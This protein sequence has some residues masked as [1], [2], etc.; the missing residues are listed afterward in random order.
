[1]VNS[2][3]VLIIFSEIL[4]TKMVEFNLSNRKLAIASRV[5]SEKISS[6]RTESCFP[7]LWTLVLIA[8]FL[9]CSVD[10]LL[11][12]S[13][14]RHSNYGHSNYGHS[15]AYEKYA[16]DVFPNEDVFA[17][18]FRN[19]LLSMMNVKG[20]TSYELSLKSGCSENTIDMYLSVHRWTPQVPVFLNLCDA[21][22]CTPSEL[23]GY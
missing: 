1:M 10:E 19:R 21:L 13:I 23:L 3:N 22:E 4:R 8:D 17:D 7:K 5:T 15:N 2:K 11:G 12:Y 9:E 16:S 6:Y 18:Y 20:M 14:C